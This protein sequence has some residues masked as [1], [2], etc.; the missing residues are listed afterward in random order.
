MNANV[1]SIPSVAREVR[2][3]RRLK[4]TNTA[5]YADAIA[6]LDWLSA[7]YADA[8]SGCL[9]CWSERCRR[10]GRCHECDDDASICR[11][12]RDGAL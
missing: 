8:E 6:R 3:L 11:R 7:P 12:T 1:S 2:S 9:S 10:C 4:R 5:A